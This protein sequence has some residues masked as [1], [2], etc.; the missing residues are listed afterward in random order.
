M[1][2]VNFRI[3]FHH[4]PIAFWM[5]LTL[6]LV[7]GLVSLISMRTYEYLERGNTKNDYPLYTQIMQD[8]PK[9]Q[10]SLY[11]TISGAWYAHKATTEIIIEFYE[12]GYFSW[13]SVDSTAKYTK[14]FAAGR[15][16]LDG[17]GRLLF[18]Q[19]K[20]LGLPFDQSNPGL[21]IYNFSLGETAFSFDIKH[22][23]NNANSSEK[24]IMLKISNNKEEINPAI[25]AFLQTIS[26]SE[27]TIALKYLG[28]PTHRDLRAQ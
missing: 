16:A 24:I 3:P 28:K 15:Y 25:T 21:R 12:D 17:Q 27:K 22:R 2:R 9:Q 4:L 18:S 23:K 19:M 14:L 13:E 1:T 7:G 5:I 20:E 10:I 26:G 6:S 8:F 11:K